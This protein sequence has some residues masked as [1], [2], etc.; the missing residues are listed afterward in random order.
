LQN[1][2]D[3]KLHCSLKFIKREKNEKNHFS[4]LYNFMIHLPDICLL[5]ARNI[6]LLLIYCTNN[7]H[8]GG[9]NIETTS[10]NSGIE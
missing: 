4:D 9:S 7:L 6:G 2:A 3:V 1:Q 5:R 10:Q 8:H